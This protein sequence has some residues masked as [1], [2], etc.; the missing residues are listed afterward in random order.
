VSKRPGFFALA[1]S[2][3]ESYHCGMSLQ[4]IS[5]TAPDNYISQVDEIAERRKRSRSF[6]IAEAIEKYLEN[7]HK[8]STPTPK[9]KA[10]TR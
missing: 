3:I 4:K 1:Q 10:G 6:I 5:I 9:K 7:G 2:R 8:P